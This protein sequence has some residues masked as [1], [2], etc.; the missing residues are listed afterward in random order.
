ML[1]LGLGCIWFARKGGE[2]DD[3]KSFN[4]E[5][6]AKQIRAALESV[7]NVSNVKISGTPSAIRVPSFNRDLE[8]TNFFPQFVALRIEFDIFFPQ[9][10]QVKYA[11][12]G[13]GSSVENFHVEIIST[14]SMPIAAISYPIAVS[15]ESIEKFSPSS[16]VVFIRKYLAEKLMNHSDIDF[17]ILGPSPFHADIFLERAESQ[18]IVLEEVNPSSRG[19]RTLYARLPCNSAEE[20]TEKFVEQYREILGSFYNV[21]GMRNVSM[22]ATSKAVRLAK[23]LVSDR[24]EESF[25]KRLQRR[26]SERSIVDSVFDAILRDRLNGIRVERYLAKLRRDGLLEP[27]NYFVRAIKREVDDLYRAPNDDIKLLLQITEDRRRGY[28]SNLS[29]LLSGIAGGLLGAAVGAYLTILLSGHASTASMPAI[30]NLT[31]STNGTTLVPTGQRPH[32]K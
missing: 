17:Q 9:R 12:R 15:K 29:T 5:N 21:V 14:F 18:E 24:T 10:L 31:S 7:D 16:A 30:S 27:E 25:I 20:L 22:F 32:P 2:P 3:W 28:F 26:Y 1:A 23:T 4:P 8:R 19:Y 11:L 6:H 13:T